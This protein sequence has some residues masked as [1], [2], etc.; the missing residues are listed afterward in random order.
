MLLLEF[1]N[2]LLVMGLFNVLDIGENC[3]LSK[4][5]LGADAATIGTELG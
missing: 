5:A 1:L 4:R 2:M 3:N